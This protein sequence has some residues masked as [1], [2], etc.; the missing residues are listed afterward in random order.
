MVYSM[1]NAKI[2]V[3]NQSISA[4]GVNA[5]QQ[6]SLFK[7]KSSSGSGTN[8]AGQSGIFPFQA[9]IVIL[10]QKQPR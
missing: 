3:P 4:N 1:M 5:I 7:V 10:N 2:P 6:L 8:Q 9:L